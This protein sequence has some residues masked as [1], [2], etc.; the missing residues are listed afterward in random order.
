MEELNLREYMD[1]NGG[2]SASTVLTGAGVACL[3]VAC[4]VS[5]PSVVVAAAG[6]ALYNAGAVGVIF[7]ACDF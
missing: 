5:A 2:V 7:G 1:M 3:G 6:Y 4:M